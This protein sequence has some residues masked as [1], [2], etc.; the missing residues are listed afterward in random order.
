MRGSP[1]LLTALA[2]AAVCLLGRAD[3]AP[4][5]I[6]IPPSAWR[7]VKRE[8]GSVNYYSV[9]REEEH[10]FLRARYRP[11][12]KTVVLGWK[13]PDSAKKTARRLRWDWRARELPVGGNDCVDGKG[14]SA[15][16]VYVTWKRGLKY[17]VLK[18]VWSGAGPKGHCRKKRN[19]FVAEDAVVVHVGPPLGVWHRVE[20][21]L[22]AEF[23][24]H[25]EGGDPQ[26]SVPDLV[27]VGLFTDGDQTKSESAAD[28]G[29]FTLSR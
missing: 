5:D 12:L 24:T 21:D 10:T 13:T 23:R 15:A 17:Y 19:P 7:V 9:A 22:R 11:P 28:Y 8:S 29:S 27:G 16:A 1:R 26:A 3:A 20:L 14:D 18:Y 4:S 6:V 25:F 2:A